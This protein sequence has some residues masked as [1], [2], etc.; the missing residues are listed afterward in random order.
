MTRSTNQQVVKDTKFMMDTVIEITAYGPQAQE[1]V[2]A[3]FAEIKRIDALMNLY[4]VNSETAKINAM[5]GQHP[6]KVSSDMVFVLEKAQYYS[7]LTEGAFDVTIGPLTTLWGIGKNGDTIPD[8]EEI[9]QARTLVDYRQLQIDQ[10]QQTVFLTK[11][12]MMID[13]GSVGKGYA[14]DQAIAVLK[15]YQVQSAL[16]NAGGSIR[17]LGN[18]PD[19]TPWRIGVQHPRVNDGLVAKVALTQW[20]AL[21][22]SGDYQRFFIKDGIRYHHILDPKTGLPSRGVISNTV[23]MNRAL[24][25]DIINTALAIL[26]QQAGAKILESFPEAE[27]I[28]VLDDET[29]VLSP[30]FQGKAEIMSTG[31]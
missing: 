9:E 11:P 31:R 27:A 8:Q 26:N 5:A 19:K 23:A 18:K 3:A 10:Q 6:V 22:T 24:D 28:W 12:G 20:D 13:L 29:V 1:A 21:D 4:D 7:E 30:G 2:P 16:V 25:A 15:R 14:V 17:V